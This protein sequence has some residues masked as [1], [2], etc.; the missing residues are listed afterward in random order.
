MTE[1]VLKKRIFFF[2]LLSKIFVICFVIIISQLG[3]LSHSETPG[4]LS[5][6]IPLFSVYIT[7]MVNE[8]IKNRYNTKPEKKIKLKPTFVKLTYIVFPVYVITIIGLLL[9]KLEG[10]ISFQQF[11]TYLTTIETGLGVYIGQIVFG[12][13]KQKDEAQP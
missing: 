2:M 4:A 5:A 3:G 1:Q 9:I 10:T 8:Y 13:F 6:L 12:L 7:V 11:Q